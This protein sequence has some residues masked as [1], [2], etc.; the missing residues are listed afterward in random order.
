MLDK[1][2]QWNGI[3]KINYDRPLSFLITLPAGYFTTSISK[4]S[5]LLSALYHKAFMLEQFLSIFATHCSHV[6]RCNTCK[7][8]KIHSQNHQYSK[9]SCK[10]WFIPSLI[11]V[12][13]LLESQKFTPRIQ[14]LKKPKSIVKQSCCSRLI[15]TT[16]KTCTGGGARPMIWSKYQPS[17]L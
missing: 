1:F 13:M 7:G 8:N 4:V 15:L 3:R 14:I 6:K 11:H 5:P 16:S 9:T 12:R 10:I 17:L 2:H